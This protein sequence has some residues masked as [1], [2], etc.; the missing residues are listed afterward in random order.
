MKYCTKS[1][2]DIENES[3][4]DELQAWYI[5][6]RIIRIS[7]SHTLV[8]QWVYQKI[9]PLENDWLYLS[10]LRLNSICEWSQKDDTFEFIDDYKKQ[11]LKYDNGLYQQF[12]DGKLV[13]EFGTKKETI[14]HSVTIDNIEFFPLTFKD[15]LITD[16][17][18]YKLFRDKK[19]KSKYPFGR[20]TTKSKLKKTIPDPVMV[21]IDGVMYQYKN[22]DLIKIP[23]VP[24]TMKNF[25][26]YQYY[27][28]LSKHI[29]TTNLVHFGITQNEC[30]KRGL[31]DDIEIQ[32]LNDFNTDME[33]DVKK[34]YDEV[35]IKDTKTKPLPKIN[36]KFL[37]LPKED[38]VLPKNFDY[39]YFKEDKKVDNFPQGCFDFEIGVQSER[40]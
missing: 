31:I 22:D 39:S 35:G 15:S 11:T 2:M 24:S 8:P 1:F 16:K 36:K 33:F 13:R 4:L 38:I 6:H 30:I 3:K 20:P 21:D 12:I 29:D 26:L 23:I 5:K 10:E 7:T 28:K 40:V 17:G 34:K 9:Y 37:S 32:S 14:K 19:F 18:S 25:E 27:L